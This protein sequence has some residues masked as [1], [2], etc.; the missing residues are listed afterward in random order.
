MVPSVEASPDR[1]LQ[2]KQQS[3]TLSLLDDELTPPFSSNYWKRR[4]VSPSYF[5]R[6]VFFRTR[7]LSFTVLALTFFSFPSTARTLNYQRD[8]PMIYKSDYAGY[9]N[10]FPNSF[11]GPINAPNGLESMFSITADVARYDLAVE[12]DDYTQVGTFGPK[13]S[14]NQLKNVRFRISLVH[15]KRLSLSFQYD[16]SCSKAH[17]ITNCFIW[18]SNFIT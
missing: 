13:Y 17:S 4:D 5:R 2:V 6:A 8:G 11:S 9:P 3:F 15:W 18:C 14:T 10:Y 16:Y 7:T 12:D 1:M